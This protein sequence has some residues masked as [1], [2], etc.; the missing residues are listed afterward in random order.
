MEDKTANWGTEKI[1]KILFRLAPPVMLAQLIQA[2][3]N[4]IDSFFVGRYSD[5]GLTALGLYYKWQT[6]FFIPL[7]AMQTCIVPVISYNFARKSIDRC[8]KTLFTSV[9]FGW[10]LMAVGTL[11]FLLIPSQMLRVFTQDE[12]VIQI[13]RVGFRFVGV[14]FLPMVTS[15]IFPVFFQAVGAGLKSSLLTVVRTVV[16]F[17]PLGYL[18]SRFGLTW[19]WLTFPVTEVLTSLVGVFFYR[20]FLRGNYASGEKCGA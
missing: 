11:C 16:L 6:F 15:L 4:I 19:F 9:C 7:G 3:Y 12:R 8:R 5:A 2:L 10:I 14:S 20:R 18:F 1:S 13:G 17:V